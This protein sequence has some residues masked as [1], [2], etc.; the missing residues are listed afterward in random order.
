MLKLQSTYYKD[1]IRLAFPVVLANV[2]QAVVQIADNIMVG[3]LGTSELASVAFAGTVVTTLLVCG[4]GIAI[5]LTPIVGSFYVSGSYRNI[6]HYFQ[7]SI[8]LNALVG[9]ALTGI[10]LLLMPALSYMG[11]PRHIV[12]LGR[13]YYLFCAFSIIPFMIFLSSKQFM[14]GI[15]NTKLAMVIT[16]AVNIVNILLNYLFIY[17]KWGFP[18]WGVTGAGFATFVSR[19]LMPV[20]FFLLIYRKPSYRRYFTFFGKAAFELRKQKHLLSLGFPI[21]GQILL[22]MSAFSISTIMMGWFGEV[23]LAAYQIVMTMT[24]ITFM[25]SNG[26]GGASTI[27]V[28]HQYGK[29]N[30][31][32]IKKYMRAGLMMSV[33]AMSVA[34]VTFIVFGK[35]IALGFTSVGEVAEMA[36]KLFVVVGLFEISDGLQVTAL[37]ALRGITDVR[38]PMLYAFISYILIN[39]PVAYLLGF[40]F[41][42]GPIGIVMGFFCGLTVAAILYIRRFNSVVK[43]MGPGL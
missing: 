34:A 8:S 12:D 38:R 30:A 29:R 31:P 14:E 37:G 3:R 27:L 13:G 33:A 23:A 35:N 2:G 42:L 18:Q 26:I 40:T 21:S 19:L 16:I 28:S 9:I 15:G 11:Q 36:A 24:H 25:F 7:N 5:S 20:L 41:G 43:K 1:N 22:E 39:L 17:G 6:S 10:L 32:E 4:I